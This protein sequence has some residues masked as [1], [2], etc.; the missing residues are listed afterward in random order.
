[1]SIIRRPTGVRHWLD[2]TVDNII[3]H[4]ELPAEAKLQVMLTRGRKGVVLHQPQHAKANGD[5]GGRTLSLPVTL[6]KK[7]GGGRTYKRKEY[8]LALL[9]REHCLAS[10]ML[11]ATDFNEEGSAVELHTP[12]M[13][14]GVVAGSGILMY[15]RVKCA[16]ETEEMS[17]QREESDTA[18]FVSNPDSVRSSL[19]LNDSSRSKNLSNSNSRGRMF[20]REPSPDPRMNPRLMRTVEAGSLT[21]GASGGKAYS[22]SPKS[23]M[24]GRSPSPLRFGAPSFPVRAIPPD[25]TSDA[26]VSEGDESA[27]E[28]MWQSMVQQLQE[29]LDMLLVEKD[30]LLQELATRQEE[31]GVP[32]GIA[33]NGIAAAGPA[34]LTAMDEAAWATAAHARDGTERSPTEVELRQELVEAMKVIEL[35][36]DALGALEHKLDKWRPSIPSMAYQELRETLDGLI[37][38]VVLDTTDMASPPPSSINL[39]NR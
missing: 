37:A 35:S 30:E 6:F 9:D 18:S 7:M 5:W 26:S 17:R 21:P 20:D 25:P 34:D 29:Q 11:D 13:E 10:F 39:V 12:D 15:L 28:G 8:T 22:L 31:D 2:V 16:V 38:A 24:S 27:S 33:H 1:M 4:R 14:P 3:I 19:S 23:S 36:A 32:N